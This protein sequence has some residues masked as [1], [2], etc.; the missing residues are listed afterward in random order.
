V[1]RASSTTELYQR[2]ESFGIPGYQIDG[3]DIF[4]VIEAAKMAL[5]YARCNGPILLEMKTYRYRGHSM[6]D[7]ATY[8]TKEEVEKYKQNRDPIDFLKK[9]ALAAKIASEE[10]FKLIDKEVKAIITETMEHATQSTLPDSSEIW[11][12]VFADDDSQNNLQ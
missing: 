9:C 2:G 10:D 3:M 8:R 4:K 5:E 1:E 11:A 12:D 7:P 6:S